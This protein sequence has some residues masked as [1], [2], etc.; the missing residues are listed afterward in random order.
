MLIE[1][2][3]LVTLKQLKQDV[4]SIFTNK[5]IF[6]EATLARALDGELI[7]L[8]LARDCPAERNSERVKLS[9]KNFAEW[10]INAGIATHRVYVDE[11]GYNLWTRR[12]YGRS[13]V[14]ERVN[15]I[16]G[17]Q[18]GRNATVV[19]A[20]S[21]KVGLL[22]HEIHFATVTKPVMCNFMFNLEFILG[23]E[24]AVIVMDNA[25]VH[26]GLQQN[27]PELEIMYLPPYSPFL[28]PIENCFSVFKSAIKRNLQ[29]DAELHSTRAAHVAGVSVAQLREN[30]LQAALEESVYCI[31][32]ELVASTYAHANSY[33][34][35]CVQCEDIFN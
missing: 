5:P 34:T 8:K 1:G 25:P 23:D 14:G 31:T 19:A 18:R 4:L 16:V 11:C 3:P 27:F 32:Q 30:I 26:H 9:R 10:M 22:Y 28:N 29:F 24:Q 21:D 2:N 7:S 13:V 20:I 35:R 6:S 12:S 15:R 33:L 17:G